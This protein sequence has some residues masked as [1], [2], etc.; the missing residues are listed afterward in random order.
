MPTLAE[1]SETCVEAKRTSALWKH[2]EREAAQ[3]RSRFALHVPAEIACL[4]VSDINTPQA[5]AILEPVWGSKP[6]Q[7]R[8]LRR[9][10]QDVIERAV[11]T[12]HHSPDNP[13]GQRI[14]KVLGAQRRTKHHGAVTWRDVPDAVQR[15]RNADCYWIGTRLALEFQILACVRPVNVCIAQ[16]SDVD[17]EAKEWRI[18]PD[19]VKGRRADWNDKPHRVPL[20]K[21][22]LEILAE[23][24]KLQ[25]PDSDLVFP[26][27]Q[28]GQIHSDAP[29]KLLRHCEIDSTRHGFR[30]AFADWA[31]NETNARRVLVK[32]CL[33]QKPGTGT[34]DS[35]YFRSTSYKRRKK[36]MRKWAKYI[37]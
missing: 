36:L 12:G 27:R 25:R 24:R 30:N 31:E 10:L 8:R 14:V 4:P 1:V 34:V 22:C 7:G 6:T 13:F 35:A 15:I 9:D 19:Q 26:A 28:G 11:Q 20:N 17:M 23:A 5:M 2:P 32:K 21:R 3:W 16:W 29:R 37:G 33:M 18:P